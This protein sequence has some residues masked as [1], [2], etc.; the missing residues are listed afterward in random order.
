MVTQM[1]FLATAGLMV[2][3]SCVPPRDASSHLPSSSRKPLNILIVIFDDLNRE[4]GPYGNRGVKTPNLDRFAKRAL[5][6]DKAYVQY[7]LCS[8]SRVSLLSGLRP[9]ETGIYDNETKTRTHLR[10]A[11]LLPELFKQ[12]GY[13]TSRVGK[14][15]HIGKDDPQSWNVSEEGTPENRVIYQPQEPDKLNQRSR[16]VENSRNYDPGHIKKQT[17]GMIG[18][19]GAAWASTGTS[20]DE[21]IDGMTAKRAVGW[22]ATRR[23]AQPFFMTVG[24]RRPHLPWIAPKTYYDLY[25]PDSVA[26]PAEVPLDLPGQ[27]PEVVA[28]SPTEHRERLRAYYA[29]ISFA[30]AQFGRVLDELDRQQRW[31]DTVVV[32]LGDHGYHLGSR[33]H[34]GKGTPYDDASAAP[35]LIAAPG[36]VAGATGQVTEFVDLYP[37]LTD[38][39]G[40]TASP[41]LAGKS[42]AGILGGATMR[43]RHTNLTTS[44]RGDL[45][46][47]VTGASRDGFSAH[48]V[49]DGRFRLIEWHRPVGLRELYDMEADPGE[50]SNVVSDPRFASVLETL[51]RAL[52]NYRARYPGPLFAAQHTP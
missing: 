18:G 52:V 1:R 19:E 17:D 22:L 37:T 39:A 41:S 36:L 32:V 16:F 27:S 49:T 5:R 21:T 28:V 43:P 50:R 23:D 4:I 25:P 14:V 48:A 44:S 24:F 11:V 42:L 2:V 33:K 9:E 12:H 45:A 26:V 51:G 29:A 34:W 20:D 10:D 7:P 3:L 47:T 46:F 15:F 30:D 31:G 35:L 6:F 40:L 38:L 8:P 13:H